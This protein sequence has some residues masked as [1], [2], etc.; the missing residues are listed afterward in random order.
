MDFNNKSTEECIALL[1]D[2][3][4]Y[5]NYSQA[6]RT[7]NNAS[8]YEIPMADGKLKFASKKLRQLIEQAGISPK[9]ITSLM[10]AIKTGLHK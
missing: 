3:P 9:Q 10:N 6:L 1:A 7:A 5:T 2:T 8:P 4:E